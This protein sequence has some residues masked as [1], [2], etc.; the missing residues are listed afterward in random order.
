MRITTR[1]GWEIGENQVTPEQA[2]L[3]RRAL[4]GGTAALLGSASGVAVPGLALAAPNP[5]YDPGRPLT[6]E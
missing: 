1:R 6:V 2:V 4:L 5:K 3:N